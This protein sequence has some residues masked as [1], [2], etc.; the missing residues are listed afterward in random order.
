MNNYKTI[1]KEPVNPSSPDFNGVVSGA[2]LLTL[3]E[4][5]QALRVDFDLDE[6]ELNAILTGARLAVEMEANRLLVDRET[7]AATVTASQ[8][9]NAKICIL[10]K[11]REIYNGEELKHFYRILLNSFANKIYCV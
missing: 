10:A 8:K 3:D 6:T 4:L 9:E 11:A 2:E 7:E 1:E 5:K